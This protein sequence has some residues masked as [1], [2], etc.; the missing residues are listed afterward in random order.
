MELESK[1]MADDH[2]TQT[3]HSTCLEAHVS[4]EPLGNFWRRWDM[5]LIFKYI[6]TVAKEGGRKKGLQTG[7]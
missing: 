2:G 1:Q 5:S 3:I 7:L 6:V 4:E